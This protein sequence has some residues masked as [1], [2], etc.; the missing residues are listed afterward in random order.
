MRRRLCAAAAL[1]V[2]AFP[3]RAD[4]PG[5]DL[6]EH[7]HWKKFAIPANFLKHADLDEKSILDLDALQN[8]HLIV[9]TAGAY[10]EVAGT[11]RSTPEMYLFYLWQS[12]KRPG[13]DTEHNWLVGELR[14]ATDESGISLCLRQLNL[15]NENG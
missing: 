14:N 5:A 15:K 7:A 10:I 13:D 1:C 9:C 3:L 6:A 4:S 12:A 2:V 11:G 8:E